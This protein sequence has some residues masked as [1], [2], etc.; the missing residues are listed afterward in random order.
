M[1][2]ISTHQWLAHIRELIRSTK[3]TKG[4]IPFQISGNVFDIRSLFIHLAL[5]V[6]RKNLTDDY[7]RM[8]LRDGF[9][10]FF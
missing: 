10:L 7:R 6:L 9:V 3:L 5:A 8:F 1:I 2:S 4:L